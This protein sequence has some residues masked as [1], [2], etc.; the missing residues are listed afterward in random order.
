MGYKKGFGDTR[1]TLFFNIAEIIKVK[2]PKIVFLEN[3]R[4][5]KNYN[6]GKS[7]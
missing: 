7:F 6:N 1:C 3:V 4:E 2:Q 5:L